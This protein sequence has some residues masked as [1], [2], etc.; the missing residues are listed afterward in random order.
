MWVAGVG[1]FLMKDSWV[2]GAIW[3]REVVQQTPRM[4]FQQAAIIPKASQ[5]Q[6]QALANLEIFLQKPAVLGSKNRRR[7]GCEEISG[8]TI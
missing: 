1:C 3:K 8:L 2:G 4:I 6:L 7:L 5:K